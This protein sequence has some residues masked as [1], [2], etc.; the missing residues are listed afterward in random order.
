MSTIT[1]QDNRWTVTGE[2]LMD[3]ASAL[4]AQSQQLT[5]PAVLSVDF[6]GVDNLDTSALSLVIE[7]LRRAEDENVQLKFTHFPASLISL[8]SLYGVTDFISESA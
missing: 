2:I 1:L 5:M 3:S 7:W 6:S 8:A 4:L